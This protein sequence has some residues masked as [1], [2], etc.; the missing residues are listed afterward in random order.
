[1]ES[2]PP[3]KLPLPVLV[4]VTVAVLDVPIRVTGAFV[5][6]ETLF[7]GAT[8]IPDRA[9]DALPADLPFTESFPVEVPVVVGLKVTSSLDVPPLLIVRLLSLVANWPDAVRVTV[10][11]FAPLLATL[12]DF[13]WDW[14][15]TR[16]SPKFKGVGPAEIVVIVLACA[17]PPSTASSETAEAVERRTV[18]ISH[19][20]GKGA[21]RD[22]GASISG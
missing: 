19:L 12:T 4:I 14:V 10:T 20:A 13:G 8:P 9:T 2:T 22:D 16:T 7:F 18:R 15:P 5:V 3:A 11:G 17:V 21:H 6:T 1:M